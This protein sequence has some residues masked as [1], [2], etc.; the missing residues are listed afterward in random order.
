MLASEM[1]SVMVW[2]SMGAFSWYVDHHLWES[3]EP[4]LGIQRTRRRF[5]VAY[6]SPRQ[7]CASADFSLL[8]F[9]FLDEGR[10]GGLEERGLGLNRCL[11][12]NKI[13]AFI[14]WGTDA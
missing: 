4:V 7:S 10:Q 2:K 6:G 12:W 3:R 11:T 13:S 8:S 5:A 14:K 9:C 1:S